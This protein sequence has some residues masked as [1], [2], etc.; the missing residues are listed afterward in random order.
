MAYFNDASCADTA[1]NSFI[2]NLALSTVAL[3]FN[4]STNSEG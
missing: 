4:T 3:A 1:F 2:M